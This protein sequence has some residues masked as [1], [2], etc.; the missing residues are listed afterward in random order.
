LTLTTSNETKS[1]FA[2]TVIANVMLP[3]STAIG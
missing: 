2:S 1:P 3:V